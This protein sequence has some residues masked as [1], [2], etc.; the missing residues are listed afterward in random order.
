MHLYLFV[1]WQ[2]WQIS[3]SK[4]TFSTNYFQFSTIVC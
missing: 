2:D 4:L 3:G 1:I